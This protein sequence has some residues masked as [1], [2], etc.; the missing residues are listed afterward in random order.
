MSG[1]ELKKWREGS[2]LTQE[3]LAELLGVAR[4]TVA[5]WERNEIGIPPF[6]S[7][8]LETLE[9]RRRSTKKISKQL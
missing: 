8:A 9:H 1:Q 5:R 3:G 7:L 6:L 4:N 2:L